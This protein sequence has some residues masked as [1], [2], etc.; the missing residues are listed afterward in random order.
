M[1]CF[2]RASISDR[3]QGGKNFLRF[4]RNQQFDQCV[5]DPNFLRVVM[6]GSVTSPLATTAFTR[7]VDLKNFFQRFLTMHPCRNMHV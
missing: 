1:I 6:P 5:L 4:S 2:E 3:D 7:G